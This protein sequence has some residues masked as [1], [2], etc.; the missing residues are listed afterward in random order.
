MSFKP[1]VTSVNLTPVKSVVIREKIQVPT[2]R[3]EKPDS[4]PVAYRLPTIRS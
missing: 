4:R 3:V 1:Q 2:D